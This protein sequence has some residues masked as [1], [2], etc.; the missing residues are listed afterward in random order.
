MKNHGSYSKIILFMFSG[1][2]IP[3]I[4]YEW[5]RVHLDSD[6]VRP[7]IPE[8]KLKHHFL[9][10]NKYGNDSSG[11]PVLPNQFIRV[12]SPWSYEGDNN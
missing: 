9:N 1:L 10:L 2:V 6:P 11:C 3:S 8:S 5:M 12:S 7:P 4:V